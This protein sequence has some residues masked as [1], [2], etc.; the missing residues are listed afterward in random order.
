MVIGGA[1]N[2]IFLEADFFKTPYEN[3]AV[4]GVGFDSSQWVWFLIGTY[5][6]PIA[7]CLQ[8]IFVVQ[9]FKS[10][11]VNYLFKLVSFYLLCAIS[12][13]CTVQ[14]THMC[15]DILSCG[16]FCVGPIPADDEVSGQDTGADAAVGLIYFFVSL[17]FSIM[18]LSLIVILHVQLARDSKSNRDLIENKS[19]NAALIPPGSVSSKQWFETTSWWGKN[20]IIFL[21]FVVFFPLMVFAIMALPNNWQVCFT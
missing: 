10:V 1:G 16:I 18:Y 5:C 12:L 11:S 8:L 17:A 20:R 13:F 7:L 6:L 9:F 4:A 3:W 21:G 2:Q 14:S 15:G 19:I